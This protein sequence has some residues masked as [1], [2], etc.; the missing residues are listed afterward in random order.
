MTN[1]EY[2]NSLPEAEKEKWDNTYTKGHPLKD[3]INWDAFLN[4]EDGNEM[5]FLI[6]KVDVAEDIYGRKGLE[7]L[8]LAPCRT[9]TSEGVVP[10]F[11][12]EVLIN[13]KPA[14]VLVGVTREPISGADCIFD[15]NII[16]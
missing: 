1:K 16:I 6:D 12:A 13:E 5:N 8:R 11:S 15:P 4:S 3:Y 14:D 9:I 2:R 10:V 7:G